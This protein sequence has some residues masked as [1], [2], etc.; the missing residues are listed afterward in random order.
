MNNVF[1]YLKEYGGFTFSQKKFCDVDALVLAQFSYLKVDGMVPRLREGAEAVTLRSLLEHP[2]R[3]KMFADERYAGNNRRLF[4]MM[5]KSVRFRDIRMNDYVSITDEQIGTQF[6]AMVIT[7]RE[8]LHYVAF[9]GTDETIVGW[10]EDFC[11][12][13]T[14]TIPSQDYSVIYLT[15][16]ADKTEGCFF[17]GGHSKGGNLAVYATLRCPE[18]IG[19][20]IRRIYSFD[21]PGFRPGALDK[22]CYEKIFRKTRRWIPQACVVGMMLQYEGRYRVV[23][24]TA[25]GLL[26]H[27]PF[28]WMIE[29]GRFVQLRALD[30]RQRRMD[31]ALNAWI[32]DMT[33][34]QIRRF[35]ENLFQILYATETDNLIELFKHRKKSIG[36]MFTA[37]KKM[38]PEEKRFMRRMLG[39]LFVVQSDWL[40]HGKK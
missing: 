40:L 38:E 13:F 8:N 24:S 17:V 16:V 35:V 2:D 19:A 5:C 29:Q 34:V 6:A 4:A 11:M 25:T 32:M 21:A 10:K 18:D 28:S 14:G 31:G 1:G 37:Y 30:K 26:Q 22:A 36:H 39:R 33:D 15:R 3:E 27:D 12:A 7:L 20:R 23:Q 9:R